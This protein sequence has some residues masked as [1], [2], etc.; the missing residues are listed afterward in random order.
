MQ[1]RHSAANGWRQGHSVAVQHALREKLSYPTQI[2]APDVSVIR[3]VIDKVIPK[4]DPARLQQR[5]H[6]MR[7]QFLKLFI[8]NRASS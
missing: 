1:L 7:Q 6:P 4:N 2:Y 5:P 8:K 3:I